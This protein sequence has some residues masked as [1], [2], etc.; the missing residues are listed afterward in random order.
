[1]T[2]RALPRSPL[3][4]ALAVA[5]AAAPTAADE[6]WRFEIDP[7]VGHT[8]HLR[9]DSTSEL[10]V[11][12]G[13]MGRQEVVTEST[14]EASQ[15]IVEQREDGAVVIEVSYSR[16]RQVVPG[17]E[18]PVV[19]DTAEGVGTEEFPLAMLDRVFTLVLGP[20]G[21][22][23]EVS[24]LEGILEEPLA[25]LESRPETAALA[26][27]MREALGPE[28]MKE[29]LQ[30]AQPVFPQEPVGLGDSWTHEFSFSNALIGDVS[31]SATYRLEGEGRL[32][33]R[34]VVRLAM[35]LMIDM[36]ESLPMVEQMREMFA[37]QGMDAELDLELGDSPGSGEIWVDAETGIALRTEMLQEL[38]MSMRMFVPG[39]QMEEPLSMRMTGTTRTVTE[40]LGEEVAGAPVG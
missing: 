5:I 16:F 28:A 22:I 23:L 2:R 1:M 6:S 30:Q 12:L 19:I 35:D 13:P 20:R 18:G 29:L 37:A 15:R 36:P 26:E 10:T 25:E 27:M 33:G 31:T 14:I 21:R 17:P 40:V 38:D 11:D 9:A 24:G 7:P 32:H 39:G 34:P 8:Y 3:P 4:F